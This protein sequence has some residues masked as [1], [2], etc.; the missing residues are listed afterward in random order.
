MRVPIPTC[1][2]THD[3]RLSLPNQ[4]IRTDMT[5]EEAVQYLHARKIL[6]APVL[7]VEVAAKPGATWKDKYVGIL[8]VGKRAKPPFD[9]LVAYV[10]VYVCIFVCVC[11]CMD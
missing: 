2:A 6:S 4:I 8:D 10:F 3:V 1:P 5:I 9:T 7:D 11:A